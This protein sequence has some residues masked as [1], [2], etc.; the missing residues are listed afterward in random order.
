[1]APHPLQNVEAASWRTASFE[2]AQY[3]IEHRGLVQRRAHPGNRIDVV[4]RDPA[5]V[6]PL[7]DAVEAARAG[8]ALPWET[9]MDRLGL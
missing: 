4:T 6:A 8:K 1:M 5:L 3:A 7:R 9:E 2:D